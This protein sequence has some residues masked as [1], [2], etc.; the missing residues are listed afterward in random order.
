MRKKVSLVGEEGVG[1]ADGLWTA[2]SESEEEA[3]KPVFKPKMPGGESDEV[4]RR[5]AETPNVVLI[6]WCIAGLERVRD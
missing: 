5:P 4:R 3:P 6:L 1:G 2:E